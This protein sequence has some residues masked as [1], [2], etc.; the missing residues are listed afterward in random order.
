MWVRS[1]G[2]TNML[3]GVLLL[4]VFLAVRLPGLGRFVTADE[5]LWL[6]Q[7]GRF[8]SAVAQGDWAA[9]EV[10]QHPGVTTTWAGALGYLAT[11]P[12]YADVDDEEMSDAQWRQF[13]R[14]Q[15]Y[16]P[17]QILAAGRAMVVLF[18][19][20]AFAASWPFAVR[21]L[22]R[23]PA[24][25]GMGL[26]ALDPFSIAHQRLLH[27]D[28]LMSAFM[29]LSVLALVDGVQQRSRG[30]LLISGIAAGLSWL[31]KSPAWM[32]A[33]LAAGLLVWTTWQG[34]RDW[35][36]IA[37]DGLFWLGAGLLVFVALFPAAWVAPGKVLGGMLTYIVSSAE[38]GYSGPVFFNGE[39]FPDGEMGLAGA[40]FYVLNWLWRSTP[41]T[42]LG[43]LAAV[44]FARRAR[45]ERLTLGTLALY[46][47][48]FG[49]LMTLGV[50]KFDRYLLPAMFALLLVA[51]WGWAQAAGW[52]AARAGRRWLAGGLAT[53]I[54]GLQ[55]LSA[56]PH[57][58]Y[59]LTYYNDALGGIE[60]AQAVMLVGWGE[61][62]DQAA[63]Y[64]NEQ[65]AEE[66]ASWYSTSFNL[67]YEGYADHIPI[68]ADLTPEQM[69]RL[70]ETDYLVVY[71]HQYQRQT[72]ADLLAL[73]DELEPVKVVELAGIEYA[74]V[75]K[76]GD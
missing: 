16:N 72:P 27:Q 57:F 43:L 46:T 3:L 38:G 2:G 65:G 66:V 22:G 62:L 58:P 59:Y 26:L 75:Y 24:A 53:L 56:L 31:T 7:S 63:A 33:P 55:G 64:L 4:V 12:A 13:L 9:T 11:F 71:V 39:V 40:G 60:E 37:L 15:G 50:K 8:L 21:L 34:T 48:G 41:L 28:G 49:L 10:S 52:V 1:E 42:V 5:G 25:I 23:W 19:A 14:V 29:L 73:L 45:S 76:L 32:L 61:G 18:C 70:L 44:G 6:R 17:A 35:K 20:A 36:Q 54:L 51:G 30:A 67:L 74:W 68:T 47:L 69:D